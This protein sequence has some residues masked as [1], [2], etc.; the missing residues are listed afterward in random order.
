MGVVTI[1]DL[2]QDIF[3]EIA[4][5]ESMG[6]ISGWLFFFD[7]S[8]FYQSLVIDFAGVKGNCVSFAEFDEDFFHWFF[9]AFFL[10]HFF[11]FLD[12]LFV[13]FFAHFGS[14]LSLQLSASW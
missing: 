6:L 2:L 5:C 9:G 12:F 11:Q 14:I 1:E 7:F 10:D 8:F 13:N 4:G 3:L